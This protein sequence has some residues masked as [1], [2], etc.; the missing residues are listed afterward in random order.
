MQKI[1]VIYRDILIKGSHYYANFTVH[2]TSSILKISKTPACY[3]V[4]YNEKTHG[5]YFQRLYLNVQKLKNSIRKEFQFWLGDAYYI[6]R[7]SSGFYPAHKP[8][9]L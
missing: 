9:Y 5:C 7:S 4:Y 6:M 8:S 1:I 3:R 2:N